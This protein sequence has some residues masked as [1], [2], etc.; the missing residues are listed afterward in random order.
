MVVRAI[1]SAGWFYYMGVSL[2]PLV[3]SCPEHSWALLFI[4]KNLEAR[5]IP[6]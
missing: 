2:L 4:A 5:A 1:C 3:A 6:E